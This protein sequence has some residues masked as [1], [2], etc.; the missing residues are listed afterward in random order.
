LRQSPMQV[1]A[2]HLIAFFIAGSSGFLR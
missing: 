2:G 1:H